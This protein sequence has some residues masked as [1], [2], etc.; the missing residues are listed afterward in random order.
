LKINSYDAWFWQITTGYIT[1]IDGG[2]E[3]IGIASV[4]QQLAG[5]INI[6]FVPFFT[7]ATI[8]NGAWCEVRSNL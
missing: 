7:L 1:I 8:R 6:K 4:G 2:F 3:T 5:C